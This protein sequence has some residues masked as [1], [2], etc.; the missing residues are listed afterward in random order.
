MVREAREKH[1]HGA[2]AVKPPLQQL[3]YSAEHN[4]AAAEVIQ[5]LT[6]S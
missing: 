3:Q 2:P 4:T 6:T 1:Y 5:Q